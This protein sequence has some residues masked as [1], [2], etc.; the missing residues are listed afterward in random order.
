MDTLTKRVSIVLPVYNE[1]K[2]I[3]IIFDQIQ[4][5]TKNLPYQFDVL[6]IN[7]GSL[8]NSLEVLKALCQEHPNSHY[9]NFSRNFGH[10]IALKAGF[11]LAQGDAV[12]CMDADLQHPPELIPIMLKHWIEGYDIVYTRRKESKDLSWFKRLSSKYF[13]KL[14]NLIS[15]VTLEQGTADFRLMDKRIIQILRNMPENNPF[16]RGLVKWMGFKKYAL[17]YQPGERLM[18]SSGYSLPKMFKLAIQGL[19]SFSTNP[20]YAAIYLGFGFSFLSLLYIPYIIYSYLFGEFV[21]GWPSLII[22][23]TFFAGLQLMILGIMG[24]YIAQIF[25]QSKQRPQYIIDHSSYPE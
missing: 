18:G 1:S 7:D 21:W 15:D 20:L 22:T 9:V 16:I 23:I 2:N 3:P 14:I 11:D 4:K 25:I 10:Q 5:I 17:D 8:D 13:Y 12:I 19:I 24:I 6:F